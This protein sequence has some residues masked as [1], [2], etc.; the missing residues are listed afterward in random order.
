MDPA[1]DFFVSYTQADRAWAEWIAWVLEEAGYTAHLEAWDFQAGSNFVVEMQRGASGADRTLAV[2]SPDYEKSLFGMAEWAA[3]FAQDPTGEKGKLLPVRVRKVKPDGLLKAVVY[4][5]LVGLD[6]PAARERLLKGLARGR[7]K[8]AMQPIFP[9]GLRP[10][11]PGEPVPPPGPEDARA[12]LQS[13]PEDEIPEP[14]PL[15]PGSHMPLSRNPLFVGREDDLRALARS[16]KAGETAAVGQIAA[17]TGLGGIGKTQLASEFVHRYGRFFAG[18]VF[19]M[20]F[21]EE[22]AVAAEVASSGRGL[23]LHPD[24]DNLPLEQQVRLTEEAWK[25]SLPRL[26]VFDNCEES[27][28]LNRWRPRHGGSRVLVTSRRSQWDPALDV[29]ALALGTLSRS[30]SLQLLHRFREDL[31]ADDPFLNEIA[32]ELGDLPLALHLKGSFL[33]RYRHAPFGQPAAYLKEL[34]RNNLLDH[35]SLQG[36][37]WGISPTGHERHVARTFAL[38][39][40][41]LNPGDPV[42]ALAQTLLARAACFAPSEPIPRSLLFATT[43]WSVEEFE[44]ARQFEEALD[45]IVSLGLLESSAKGSLVMHRLVA[46]F[47]RR[48]SAVGGDGFLESVEETLLQEVRRLNHAGYPAPL[49]ELQSHLLF[50]TDRAREREDERAADLCVN[51]GFFLLMVGDLVRARLYFDLSLAIREKVSGAEHP[52]MAGSLNNLGGLLSKQGDYSGARDCYERA[53]A[54]WEKV[55][56]PEHPETARGLNN[57]GY[58]L[59]MQ[60]NYSEARGCYERA[61]AIWENV[62]G[63]KHRETSRSLNNLGSLLFRQGDYSGAH[64]YF[65]RALAIQQTVLG[66]EHPETALSL[67]NLSGLLSEQGDYSGARV[68]SERALAINEKVLGAEHPDTARSLNNL[69][70]LLESQGDYSGAWDYYE[71]ALAIFSARLGPDHPSTKTVQDNLDYLM[72]KINPASPAGLDD[73]SDS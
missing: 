65:E 33:S 66:I 1:I 3:A 61:L 58:I 62:C 25:S 40:E 19:W 64:G 34:R 16:L 54:I 28:L 63:A 9:G 46:V 51:L 59:V 12:Q 47:S 2:L 49:L 50:V 20:S 23:G 73:S 10:R 42:D 67:N 68:Y 15:P 55:S 31:A 17:A 35:P 72:N 29:R 71:R 8:P 57:L 4:I 37:G 27:V 44:T 60:G 53:L 30:E 18:G 43:G 24:Y 70:S 26:L 52:E 21:A 45:R 48:E 22:S 11:F 6:E 69:G 36:K 5:D 39:Y 13:L 41:R 14:G 38:S 7:A 32:A 56:G